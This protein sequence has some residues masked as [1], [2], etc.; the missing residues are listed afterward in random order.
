MRLG[1]KAYVLYLGFIRMSRKTGHWS[2]ALS[3]AERCWRREERSSHL[4]P[5]RDTTGK[6]CVQSSTTASLVSDDARTIGI[7]G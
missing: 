1:S 6:N 5:S 4:H 3:V 2:V 7:G